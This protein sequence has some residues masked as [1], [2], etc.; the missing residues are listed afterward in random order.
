M[1][2]LIPFFDCNSYFNS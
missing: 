1:F 2:I